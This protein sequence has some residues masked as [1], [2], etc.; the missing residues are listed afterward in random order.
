VLKTRRVGGAET[1]ILREADRGSLAVRREWTDWDTATPEVS[2]LSQRLAFESLLKLAELA[3][4]L[5][6]T[7]STEIDR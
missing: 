4:H 5:A 1:L 2:S 3:E 7:A 6:A